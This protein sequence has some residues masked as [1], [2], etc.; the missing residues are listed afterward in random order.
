MVSGALAGAAGAV[1]APAAVAA[2]P[3]AVAAP[4][5]TVGA[6]GAV[7]GALPMFAGGIQYQYVPQTTYVPVAPVAATQ[8]GPAPS[9]LATRAADALDRL[10]AR[11]DANYG[12]STSGKVDLRLPQLPKV[13]APKP[14]L[15]TVA[16]G[17]ATHTYG[18]GKGAITVPDVR[19]T[20]PEKTHDASHVLQAASDFLDSA[21]TAAASEVNAVATLLRKHKPRQN[22][23]QP[24]SPQQ[25]APA[26]VY[27]PVPVQSVVPVVSTSTVMPAYTVKAKGKGKGLSMPSGKGFFG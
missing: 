25:V 4:M 27:T 23:E 1:A 26:T 19:V 21:A 20:L 6:V 9:N 24:V 12:N 14:A 3:A 13:N 22:E 8:S 5:A 2:A 10:A 11:L 16:V 17:N 15:P 18:K 7:G